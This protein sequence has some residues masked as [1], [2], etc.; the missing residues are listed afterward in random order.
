M[1]NIH[2]VYKT[3]LTGVINIYGSCIELT[4]HAKFEIGFQI[5][6]TFNKIISKSCKQFPIIFH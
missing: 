3:R 5:L 1:D 6:Y 2:K 4:T